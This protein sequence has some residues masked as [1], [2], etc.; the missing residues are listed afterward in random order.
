MKLFSIYQIEPKKI[1]LVN[2]K[3]NVW[4]KETE[5]KCHIFDLFLFNTRG[6]S[7]LLLYCH[8]FPLNFDSITSQLHIYMRSKVLITFI[9]LIACHGE[10]YLDTQLNE[11]NTIVNS[12][13]T[14]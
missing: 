12:I 11:R 9:Q 13:N 1:G 7:N 6:K 3:E 14:N 2:K 5:Y 10:Y 4:I 8:V